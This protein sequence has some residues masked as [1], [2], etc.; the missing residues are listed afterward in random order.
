MGGRRR[1]HRVDG[2]TEAGEMENSKPEKGHTPRTPHTR[3]R[4]RLEGQH[5]R[6]IKAKDCS[7]RSREGRVGYLRVD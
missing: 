5:I 1:G 4:T 7:G 3:K 6:K 2:M